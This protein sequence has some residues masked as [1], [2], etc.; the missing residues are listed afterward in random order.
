MSIQATK[1]LE[2]CEI[3]SKPHNLDKN[4]IMSYLSLLEKIYNKENCDKL[5]QERIFRITK[6]LNS[7]KKYSNFKVSPFR[8]SKSSIQKE[9]QKVQNETENKIIKENEDEQKDIEDIMCMIE[10]ELKLNG[11]DTTNLENDSFISTNVK[12]QNSNSVPNTQSK[13]SPI[14]NTQNKNTQKRLSKLFLKIEMKLKTYLQSEQENDSKSNILGKEDQKCDKTN[15]NNDINNKSNVDNN[16]KIN[17]SKRPSKLPELENS[18]FSNKKKV[19][20]ML[21][22][23]K[24]WKR[25]SMVE[26]KALQFS[27][28][29]NDCD[30]G[31]IYVKDDKN[32]NIP[33][34]KAM[35]CTALLKKPKKKKNPKNTNDKIVSAF[36]Y[37]KI[38]E[39]DEDMVENEEE[40]NF[41][42]INENQNEEEEKIDEEK[43]I[44]QLPNF[45]D[46]KNAAS[47][48]ITSTIN[49]NKFDMDEIDKER[50][51]EISLYESKPCFY[52]VSD[53]NICDYSEVDK[54]ISSSSS[55]DDDASCNSINEDEKEDSASGKSKGTEEKKEEESSKKSDESENSNNS[56][57][58]NNESNSKS[59]SGSN[60]ASN[61]KYFYRHS[62]FSP[63]SSIENNPEKMD[64]I[65]EKFGNMNL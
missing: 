2:S 20:M 42:K 31:I 36:S 1:M 54:N 21:A 41:D 6:A 24:K 28:L 60:K 19:E 25:K 61:F 52:I 48:K 23:A 8:L 45:I 17:L 58:S 59:S 57:N 27:K 63:F 39:K 35:P 53:H 46:D 11:I 49:K 62:I 55:N 50:K 32:N 13:D 5:H 9:E 33:R 51:K 22:R 40:I 44:S 18:F 29:K 14:Q 7:I 10:K 65:V 37:A 3:K 64:K 16:N 47:I 30:I 12:S 43:M 38:D 34:P 4:Q 15:D 56:D 26:F